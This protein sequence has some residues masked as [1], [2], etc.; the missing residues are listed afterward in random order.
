[1]RPELHE[2]GREWGWDSFKYRIH[3]L[4]FRERI[5]KKKKMTQC[6]FNAHCLILAPDFPADDNFLDLTSCVN[7]ICISRMCMTENVQNFSMI[8]R[9]EPI[10]GHEADL[11]WD[12]ARWGGAWRCKCSLRRI[13]SQAELLEGERSDEAGIIRRHREPSYTGRASAPRLQ[14][15]TLDLLT[16]NLQNIQA[17]TGSRI[18]PN[19]KGDTFSGTAR[20][21][22]EELVRTR[23]RKIF[24]FQA[25]FY[26][27]LRITTKTTSNSS[28]KLASQWLPA[29]QVFPIINWV[30]FAK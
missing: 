27:L 6:S 20:E 8:V 17:Q 25:N 21:V 5:L 11:I 22:P 29:P 4:R 26:H 7:K 30:S 18:D 9:Y 12:T 3:L 2:H 19:K 28:L 1:M 16:K 13:S 23:R 24:H 14:K 10:P 15:H